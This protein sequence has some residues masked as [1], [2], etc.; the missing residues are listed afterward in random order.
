M[1]GGRLERGGHVPAL[2]QGERFERLTRHIGDQ[3]EAAIEMDAVEE[4]NRH[5]LHDP[6]GEDIPRAGPR[7]RGVRGEGNMLRADAAEDPFPGADTGGETL[8][9]RDSEYFYPAAVAKRAG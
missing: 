4:P 7:W 2:L 6:C 1:D 3:V 8:D 5:D 9:A